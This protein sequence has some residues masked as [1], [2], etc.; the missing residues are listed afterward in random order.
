MRASSCLL[1]FALLHASARQRFLAPLHVPAHQ[2]LLPCV[3]CGHHA[4][5][6]KVNDTARDAGEA[7]GD[8]RITLSVNQRRYMHYRPPSYVHPIN[9]RCDGLS[10]LH[11]RDA[12]NQAQHARWGGEADLHQDVP[13]LNGA[14]CSGWARG[15]KSFDHQRS[16]VGIIDA[17][18]YTH[19][20]LRPAEVSSSVC[21]CAKHMLLDLWA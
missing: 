20:A 2:R 8:F 21:A 11:T 17:E 19:P 4:L 9:L 10:H 7:Q 3:S 5:A 6:P 14:I 16:I 15:D 13:L 12:Q 1:F 18:G